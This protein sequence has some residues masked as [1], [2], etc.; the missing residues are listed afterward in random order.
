VTLN[1]LFENKQS[2]GMNVFFK[3]SKQGI[4]TAAKKLELGSD[5]K[6]YYI[7]KSISAIAKSQFK[8]LEF[9]FFGAFFTVT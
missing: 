9:I 1:T 4:P 3:L 8:K 5:L 7:K 2:R 6:D